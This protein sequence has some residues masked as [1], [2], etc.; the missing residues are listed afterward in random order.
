VDWSVDI[1]LPMATVCVAAAP[2]RRLMGCMRIMIRV[3][4]L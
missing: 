2:L 1:R 3:S 4:I